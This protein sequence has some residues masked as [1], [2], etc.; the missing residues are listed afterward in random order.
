MTPALHERT[1]ATGGR[2]TARSASIVLFTI[3]LLA[4]CTISFPLRA[5]DEFYAGKVIT[6]I[7]D[8]KG[9]YERYARTFMRYMPKYIPGHPNMIV[10]AMPG[11]SGVKAATY[12]DKIAPRDGTVIAG[13][14]GAVITSP[15]LFPDTARYDPNAFSWIGN[16]TR[17]TYLAYVWHT[18]PIYSVNDFRTKPIVV[19]GSSIGGAGIDM[20]IIAKELFGFKIKIV[21]GYPTSNDTKLAMERGEIQGTIANGWS[22]LNTT[23]WLAKKKVRI[24]I[25]HG[26]KKR[27]DLQDIP[28]FIEL[29]R[30]DE[31]RK[32]IRLMDVREEIAKPYLAP[33]GLPPDR[34]AILRHAFDATMKDPGFLGDLK[35]ANM[36]VDEPLSGAE[37]AATVKEISET[38]PSVIKRLTTLFAEA[39]DLK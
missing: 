24:I 27:P 17:D 10:K 35:S 28:L 2:H 9:A 29:A 4:V 16:A 8:G 3:S 22:S 30:N 36:E 19:G 34:L 23:D 25:Q 12:L 31:E 21:S 26:S 39:K 15:L 20:A 37:L 1:A 5:E 14:H 7:V 18:A 11:A 38:P 6:I 33:P 32:M 13:L